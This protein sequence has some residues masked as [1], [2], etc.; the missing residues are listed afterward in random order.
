MKTKAALR[1][2]TVVAPREVAAPVVAAAA[3]DGN[4]IDMTEARVPGWVVM[5]MKLRPLN[6]SGGDNI[7]LIVTKAESSQLHVTEGAQGEYLRCIRARMHSWL[8]GDGDPDVAAARLGEYLNAEKGCTAPGHK[9]GVL[10]LPGK[11]APH[12]ATT[13][14]APGVRGP[15][16]TPRERRRDLYIVYTAPHGEEIHIR[17][18]SAIGR[19]MMRRGAP[20]P[21]GWTH[22]LEMMKSPLDKRSLLRKV[23]AVEVRGSKEEMILAK[24]KMVVTGKLPPQGRVPERKLPR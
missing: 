20:E 7:S 24:M 22:R 15:D 10:R 3:R 5:R 9:W 12:T 14:A 23:M 1:L 18:S 8:Q 19:E 11:T 13:P 17:A 16:R 6:L 21:D 2:Y 4:P